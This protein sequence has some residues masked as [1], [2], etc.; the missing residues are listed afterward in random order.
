[1]STQFASD[2]YPDYESMLERAG[3]KVDDAQTQPVQ[4]DESAPWAGERAA[5]MRPGR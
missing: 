3:V 1:V 2:G 4:F 5:L